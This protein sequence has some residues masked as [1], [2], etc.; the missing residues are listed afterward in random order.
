MELAHLQGKRGGGRRA[1]RRAHPRR[2]R[3]GGGADGHET[4]QTVRSLT[5]AS[6][7]SVTSRRTTI[8]AADADGRS[9]GVPR[10][11]RAGEG[12]RPLIGPELITADDVRSSEFAMGAV[13]PRASWR[14]L[15]V[16]GRRPG[17]GHR[18]VCG[19]VG[20]SRSARI[21]LAPVAQRSSPGARTVRTRSDGA[22]RQRPRPGLPTRSRG[23][24]RPRR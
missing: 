11:N 12:R 10:L 4:G 23:R 22:G 19:R 9:P 3:R 20:S 7:P 14:A 18:R 8:I 24:P 15:R 1:G 21:R 17:G 2:S 6:P 16:R 13:D 5:A